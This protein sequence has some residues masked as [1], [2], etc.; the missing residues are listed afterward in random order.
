MTEPIAWPTLV[1]AEM[2]IG[3]KPVT[4]K[5]RVVIERLEAEIEDIESPRIPEFEPWPKP[6]PGAEEFDEFEGRR[7][8][9][10]ETFR[11]EYEAVIAEC[12]GVLR[13]MRAAADEVYK[14]CEQA[15]LSMPSGKR[16]A[17]DEHF[18]GPDVRASPATSRS[19]RQRWSDLAAETEARLRE[20]DL[21]GLESLVP[22]IVEFMKAP[23]GGQ[24]APGHVRWPR[25]FV[26]WPSGSQQLR[27]QGRFD[28]IESRRLVRHH[29]AKREYEAM[30][31]LK[32]ED[33]TA[34]IALL[35][36]VLERTKPRAKTPVARPS[37]AADAGTAIPRPESRDEPSS[38]LSTRKRLAWT[39]LPTGVQPFAA[40]LDHFTRI[41]QSRPERA[42]DL[43]RLR[44]IAGLGPD[45]I[46]LGRDE[47]TG[48]AVFVFR[49]AGVSVLD[50]PVYGNAIY[51]IER[52]QWEVL[53]RRTKVE[54]LRDHSARVRRIV[55]RGDWLA[56]L[57]ARVRSSSGAR[58]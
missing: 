56:R 49:A 57:E 6:Y 33:R 53:A 42:I 12:R 20:D 11:R 52:E 10:Y 26:P 18:T 36:R 51:V 48:Y 7:R 46:W 37:V 22:E 21:R 19:V 2:L 9:D 1:R 50:C 40:V 58:T 47:F 54:L 16:Q 38:E 35:G 31:S 17:T 43:E 27:T 14:R 45:E 30:G 32:E 8:R 24:I 4:K 3:Q 13:A 55:H 39:A 41:A 28:D 5:L 44:Q 15:G 29:E 25:P 34:R 23:R